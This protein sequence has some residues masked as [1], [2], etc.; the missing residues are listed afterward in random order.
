M[1]SARYMS[2]EQAAGLPTVDSRTDVWS[3]GT[4]LYELLAG[5]PAFKARTR[6]ESLARVLTEDPT[7]LSSFCPD[8]PLAI[9]SAI[10][11]CLR[12]TLGERL[13]TVRDLVAELAPFAPPW[14]KANVERVLSSR[15]LVGDVATGEG[16][17]AVDRQEAST[18]T[19][20]RAQP[21]KHFGLAA[22]ACLVV[23]AVV[24]A[25]QIARLHRSNARVNTS[26]SASPTPPAGPARTSPLP[27]PTDGARRP[28]P[29]IELSPIGAARNVNRADHVVPLAA[30]GV[31]VN[32]PARARIMLRTRPAAATR[33]LGP[34]ASPVVSIDPLEGRR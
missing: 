23:V 24:L 22:L 34:V 28:V 16:P 15:T 5:V 8:A 12:K 27:A 20:M 31:R 1:G 10:Q 14:A 32:H 17:K 21:P 33:P 9:D 6:A 11:R 30:H 18:A 4:I 29:E 13:A 26:A 19:T 25:W 2:P 3:L 7:P